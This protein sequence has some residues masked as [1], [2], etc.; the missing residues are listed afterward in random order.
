M[1]TISAVR[2][3]NLAVFQDLGAFDFEE[4]K[5]GGWGVQCST[6][7]AFFVHDMSC[8]WVIMEIVLPVSMTFCIS[9]LKSIS[10]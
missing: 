5:G 8:L 7:S 9:P 3:L 4:F 6:L 1:F 2:L 10:A